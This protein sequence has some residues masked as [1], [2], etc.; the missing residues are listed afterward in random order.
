MRGRDT[1]D[2]RA[3]I[4]VPKSGISYIAFDDFDRANSSDLGSTPIGGFTWTKIGGGWSIANNRL[5]A[6]ASGSQCGIESGLVDGIIEADCYVNDQ[7]SGMLVRYGGSS[8]NRAFWRVENSTEIRTVL[9]VGGMSIYNTLTTFP[10]S[11]GNWHHFASEIIGTNYTIYIDG[12]SAL[13]VSLGALSATGAK[14]GLY[15]GVLAEQFDNFSI[16]SY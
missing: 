11:V 1:L 4:S 7:Q 15:G 16:I 9:V 13:T 8:N 3:R 5:S 2:R 6:S 14:Q 10:V 12:V